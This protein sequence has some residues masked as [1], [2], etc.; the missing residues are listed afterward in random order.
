[1]SF[2]L[3][4]QS[5][6]RRR[7]R[8]AANAAEK[9]R[10]MLAPFILERLYPPTPTETIPG[11]GK[12]KN[13]Y[14]IQPHQK[15]VHERFTPSGKKPK[16]TL[17]S[18]GVGAGKSLTMCAEM[19]RQLRTYPGIQIVVVTAFDYY[20]DEFLMPIW[21]QVLP[22]DSPHIKSF[23]RKSRSVVLTNGSRIRFKAYDDPDKIKGWQA[24]RIW[25][26]EGSEI[27]DGNNDK[28]REIWKALLMR[29]RATKPGYA[30]EMYVTQNPKGHNW[31]WS[32]FIKD[33]PTVEKSSTPSPAPR[34]QIPSFQKDI[35]I[36]CSAAWQTILVSDSGWWKGNS[37]QS[38]LWSTTIRSSQSELTLWITSGS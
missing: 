34:K 36:V 6:C 24:H 18:S 25:I 31:L 33:E 10:S 38:I 27:G 9:V 21:N 5:R 1:M 4:L 32:I 16:F 14:N 26:E 28:A 19:M 3:E 35:L 30:L 22:D 2:T 23:N 11:S 20:F 17:F 37:T 7:S 15:K 8:M 12:W 29:L 13:V